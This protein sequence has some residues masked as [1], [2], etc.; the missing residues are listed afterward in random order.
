MGRLKI[1]VWLRFKLWWN[2]LRSGAKAVDTAVSVIL[3]FLGGAVSLALAGGLGVVTHIALRDVEGDVHTVGLLIVFWFLAFAA[4][5]LPIFFG[6]GQ[7]AVPIK[8]LAVFPFATFGLYRLSLAASGA[9]ANHVFWYPM[10][11]A[12]SFTAIVIDGVP[13]VLWVAVVIA[14]SVCYVVWCNTILLVIQRV[15]SGRNVREVAALVGLVLLVTVSMIPALFE[16]QEIE[17]DASWIR[18]PD[19]GVTIGKAIASIFPPSIASSSL[20]AGIRGEYAAVLGGVMGLVLW[21]AAGMTVGFLVLRR[22]LLDGDVPSGG[23]PAGS[24]ASGGRAASPLSI[25][26]VSWIQVGSRAIA[27]KELHYLLRSTVGK[28]NIVIM[29]IFVIVMALVVARDMTAPILGLDRSSLVFVGV[30]VYASMFSNNF[31]YNA[32]AW[33]GAG[34]RSYFISPVEPSG[35]VLGK[36]VGLWLYNVILAFECAISYCVVAGVPRPTILLSGVIAYTIA[37]LS[38]TI[39][40]N[41]ISVS[42]PVARDIS[43]ITNSPSQ[44]GV[45]ASFGM[46]LVNAILIGGL[47]AIPA[48]LGVA[49]LCPVLLG[50]L[51]VV[52]ITAYRVFLHPAARLLLERREAL[53]GAVQTSN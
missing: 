37:L 47:M 9:S 16:S 27:A 23:R 20:V 14:L 43:K 13:A 40:G 31:L 32:F 42:M 28:F 46:L 45:L 33:D 8:R 36:N 12:V 26:H 41:F 19:R 50:A 10:L 5:V 4:V 22:S 11:V 3:T 7:P 38:S 6:M 53:I 30:M 29:P 25:D 51:L 18:L 24:K 34:V 21:S 52:E 48:L 15:L 49:W 2:G 44:T 35:V 39:A 1:L 17:P